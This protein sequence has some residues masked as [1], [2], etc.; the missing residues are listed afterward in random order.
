MRGRELIEVRRATGRLLG[1]D[2]ALARNADDVARVIRA[3]DPA[4]VLDLWDYERVPTLAVH[5][6]RE[7]GVQHPDWDERAE[8][9]RQLS[10]ARAGVFELVAIQV[11]K[12]LAADGIPAVLLKGSPLAERLYGDPSL[13]SPSSDVD[14]LVPTKDLFRAADLVLALGWDELELSPTTSGLPRHHIEV[15]S[16]T[17]PMV[18]VHWRV[19]WYDQHDHADGLLARA[20]THHAI[21]VLAP[22]DLLDV[23]LLC[24][25]RD[26]FHSLRLGADIAAWWRVFGDAHGPEA[27]GRLWPAR[28]MGRAASIAA[29]AAASLFATPGPQVPTKDA[30]AKLAVRIAETDR[31]RGRR[32]GGPTQS[33]LV[34]VLV[35]PRAQR[36][37]RFNS[38]WALDAKLSAAAHPW[39]PAP[40]VPLLR[41]ASA[42]TTAAGSAPIVSRALFRA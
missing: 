2:D 34:D 4:A 22:V 20:R 24:W 13:R 12:R 5:R 31:P 3:A 6:A 21:P 33:G 7:L 27:Q 29:Q 15:R 40:V 1:D 25:A 19:Q 35:C 30:A 17:R 37:E 36:L 42:A 28:P 14:V 23:L 41:A 10:A 38:T 32:V 11:T 26:G 39:A 18:E 16:A 8:T 9:L